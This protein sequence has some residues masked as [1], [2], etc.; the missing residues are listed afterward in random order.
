MAPTSALPPL[1][2][3][4]KSIVQGVAENTA[5][6][7]TEDAVQQL[8]S[9]VFAITSAGRHN[10]NLTAEEHTALWELVCLLWVGLC[11]SKQ[12]LLQG[13]QR[14]TDC[15][16]VCIYHDWH[17]SICSCSLLVTSLAACRTSVLM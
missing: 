12:Q 14:P 2:T 4:A 9:V 13:L 7:V 11:N 3:H 6:Q 8:K 1:L 17:R 15:I 5:E 10:K 16:N